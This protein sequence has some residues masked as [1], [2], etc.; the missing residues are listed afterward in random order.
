MTDF[1][2]WL[3]FALGINPTPVYGAERVLT[4]TRVSPHLI[5]MA[6]GKTLPDFRKHIW[7]RALPDATGSMFDGLSTRDIEYVLALTDA[8]LDWLY[9][10]AG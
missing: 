5:Q 2:L 6:R 1:F 7:I 3:N 8:Y 4:A 10:H 9:A